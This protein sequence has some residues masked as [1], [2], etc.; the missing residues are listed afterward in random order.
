MYGGYSL[1]DLRLVL[2]A[3]GIGLVMAVGAYVGAQ[4]VRL[5]SDNAFKLIVEAV[6]IVSGVVLIIEGA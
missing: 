4:V 1:V 5:F 3:T 2:I 6:M